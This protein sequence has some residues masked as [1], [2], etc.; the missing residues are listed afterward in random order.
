MWTVPT[1][2]PLLLILILW[3]YAAV[4]FPYPA[5]ICGAQYEAQKY[6]CA[7]LWGSSTDNGLYSLAVEEALTIP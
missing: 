7:S 5:S 2:Y 1:S 6:C 4:R 3:I